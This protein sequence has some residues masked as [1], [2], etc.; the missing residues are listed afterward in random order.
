M[1]ALVSQRWRLTGTPPTSFGAMTRTDAS[2]F[3]TGN[4]KGQSKGGICSW[5]GRTGCLWQ[6]AGF[7]YA[8]SRCMI[9]NLRS[10]TLPRRWS[11]P[12]MMRLSS[13][14]AERSPMS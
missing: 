6:N 8:L 7:A 4:K 3:G 11:A 10:M 13:I 9:S 2:G 1:S 12:S 14:C 5:Q